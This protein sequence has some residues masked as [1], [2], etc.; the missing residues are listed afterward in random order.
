[1]IRVSQSLPLGLLRPEIDALHPTATSA[2]TPTH[3][4]APAPTPVSTSGIPSLTAVTSG[5]VGLRA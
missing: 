3:P 1:M 2:P 5:L 4:S